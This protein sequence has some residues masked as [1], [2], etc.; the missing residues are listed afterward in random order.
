MLVEEVD[1]RDGLLE[2]IK[3][4]SL[5]SSWDKKIDYWN[6]PFRYFLCHEL[7]HVQVHCK[8]CQ[9]VVGP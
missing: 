2:E 5:D 6:V 1:I 8:Q 7:N 4:V 3:L 9:S